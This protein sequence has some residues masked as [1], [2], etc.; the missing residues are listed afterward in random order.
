M[1]GSARLGGFGEVRLMPK[2]TYYLT[3]PIYYVND[4]PH[5]GNAYTTIIAD[6]VAR[7]HRLKGESTYFLTGTDENATKVAAAAKDRGMDTQAFV[8][9]LAAQFKEVWKTL[10]INY[11]DFIRTTEPRHIK[12][13][14][15]IFSRFL[16][17][18]DIYKGNYEGWYCV[19]CETFYA[20]SE[21]TEGKCP[22]CGREVEWVAE[23]N[24][25]FKLSAYGDKLLAYIDA[26]PDFLQP[27]FRKNEVV[28]FI[29]QGLR[30]VSITRNNQGWGIEVPGDPG[31]VI[32][33]WFDALINYISAIGYLS[34]DEKFNSI[35]PA[36][37]QLMGKDIFVRFHCTFWPAMLMALDL[38]LPKVLFGH[39]FWTLDGEK[40]SKSK[41]NAISPAKLA[42]DL[43]EESG[44]SPDVCLDAVRYFVAREVSFG[45]DGDFSIASFRNRF[46]SDL[47]NDLGNLLNRTLSM[48]NKYFEGAIPDPKGFA[49]G[50]NEVIEN[51]QKSAA[52]SFDRL[53]FTKGLEA[54]W[55]IISAGNKFINDQKPWE[56]EKQGKTDE[57]AGVLYSALQAAR[58]AA[59]M[60]SPFM[61]ATALEIAR[62]LGI[63]DQ[64]ASLKWANASDAQPFAV[65]TKTQGPDPI[66]P[67]LGSKKK[68]DSKVEQKTEEAPQPQEAPKP[69]EDTISYDYFAKMKLRVAEVRHAERIEGADKLLKLQISLGDEERQ[70]V[71]G[72][73]QAYAPEELVGK[74][75]VIIANLEPAKIRGVVSNGMLLAADLD[76]K[77]VVLQPEKADT[78]AGSK[79]K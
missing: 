6:A 66:F 15:A 58:A 20:E 44:A 26:N 32:Y 74:K 19:P 28:N 4:V 41:G 67:R 48:L 63:A 49:G 2:S 51:A 12:V 23:E 54:V 1:T 71:A 11:D 42:S 79:V 77:A 29:K 22:S 64:F 30:D 3:T 14:Q 38:P 27:E 50:L 10:D 36:D 75:I 73:A 45:L 56:L 21:L 47:A 37:L 31:K 52:E 24:Y 16:E 17:Q 25:Y 78:P 53:E 57:L 43:A 18:G 59:I 9:Q 76:G 33:V 72:I 61:P 13:V 55:S 34:D 46:N 65:G 35:W 8:D 69:Q 5:I 60:I 68:E 7:Y 39:G 62:Q 70:I 40:I